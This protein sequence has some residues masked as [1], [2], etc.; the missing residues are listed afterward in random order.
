MT[1]WRR[2]WGT[3]QRL[4]SG[5]NFSWAPKKGAEQATADAEED[6]EDTEKKPV[7]KKAKKK[8]KKK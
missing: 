3:Q 2:G 6:N 4:R 1:K 8:K 7:A 5:E